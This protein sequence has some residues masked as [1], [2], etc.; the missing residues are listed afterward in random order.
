MERKIIYVANDGTEFFEEKECIAYERE[1]S[2]QEF[3]MFLASKELAMWN[4]EHEPIIN[5]FIDEHTSWGLE[6]ERAL[7]GATYISVKSK[8]AL[9]FLRN[10]TKEQGYLAPY[11]IGGWIWDNDCK[12]WRKISDFL[13]EAITEIDFCRSVGLLPKAD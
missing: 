8:K 7:N 4:Y 10:H 11:E 3:S 2:N 9:T 6:F 5:I 12:M 13:Q 1:T